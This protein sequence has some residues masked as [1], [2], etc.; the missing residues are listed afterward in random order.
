MRARGIGGEGMGEG[1]RNTWREREAANINKFQPPK[2]S[3]NP[4]NHNSIQLDYLKYKIVHWKNCLGIPWSVFA[5]CTLLSGSNIISSYSRCLL[6]FISFLS[7][8]SFCIYIFYAF[9][10]L[11]A[12]PMKVFLATC[13]LST[14]FICFHLFKS[15]FAFLH[16]E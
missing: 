8:S 16:K 7:R 13:I 1:T 9:I 2:N 5:S 10:L 15:F 4:I 11:S 6:C 12:I 14:L 3:T